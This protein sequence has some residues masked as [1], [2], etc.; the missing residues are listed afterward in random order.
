MNNQD[1]DEQ[2][3][4]LLY[5]HEAIEQMRPLARWVSAYYHALIG[6]GVDNSIALELAKGY[7]TS[8]LVHML[9]TLPVK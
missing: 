2:L 7:Q 6:E 3:N 9:K 1:D 8:W 4:N 5:D